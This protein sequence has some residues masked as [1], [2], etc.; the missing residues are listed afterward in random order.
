[1]WKARNIYTWLIPGCPEWQVFHD[2]SVF[3]A[4]I[5]GH[6]G[7]GAVLRYL[8]RGE[9]YDEQICQSRA[10]ARR[11]AKQLH[12][13]LKALGWRDERTSR[14]APARARMRT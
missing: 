14:T 8:Y 7:G 11:D 13:R 6:P 10:D 2:D 9:L 4:V 3:E 1:M 12:L 5:V